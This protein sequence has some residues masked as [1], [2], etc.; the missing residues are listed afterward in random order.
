[1][2]PLGL[3]TLAGRTI[4]LNRGSSLSFILRAML[5]RRSMKISASMGAIPGLCGPH[6]SVCRAAMAQGSMGCWLIYLTFS[7]GSAQSRCHGPL[8]RYPFADGPVRSR[9]PLFLPRKATRSR[10]SPPAPPTNDG[11][12]VFLPFPHECTTVQAE[13]GFFWSRRHAPSVL[14]LLVGAAQYQQPK[15]SIRRFGQVG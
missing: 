12:D 1:L 7:C 6:L 13:S 3:S 14:R 8:V 15:P 2:E 4:G 10:S 5:S 11:R 9:P